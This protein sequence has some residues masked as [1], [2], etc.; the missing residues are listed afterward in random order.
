MTGGLFTWSNNQENLVMEKFD[1]I[2]INKEWEDL[3]PQANVKRLP[4]EVSDHNP[5]IV[6]TGSNQGLP[7]IRF[8]FDLNWL[9]D[10][11]FFELAEKIWKKPCRAKTSLDKIQQKLKLFKQYF[12]G[13][14]FNI[15]GEMRKVRN[16]NKK[17][18]NE[19]ETL[20][21]QTG[22]SDDQLERK[23]WL[24]CENLKSLEQEEVYWYERS[25][26]NWLLKGDNNTA[27]FH[28]CANGRKRKNNI[29]SLEKDG[30]TIDD[31]ENLL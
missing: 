10:P 31:N 21:E 20:E 7:F 18:S 16:K 3:F 13:W 12:K 17:E 6:S 9:K 23:S 4:R 15:Q 29:V 27:F 14:G 5:L 26:S 25:H 30:V 8:K 24:I 2:L 19:L 11:E 1:R 22:L 28:K